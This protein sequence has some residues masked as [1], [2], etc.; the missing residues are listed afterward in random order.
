ML[1]ATR[2]VRLTNWSSNF[3]YLFIILIYIISIFN[4]YFI[5]YILISKWIKIRKS[6]YW[7]ILLWVP[8]FII[9]ISFFAEYFPITNR[10]EIPPPIVGLIVIGLI[11]LYPV[12]LILIITSSHSFISN[13]I[14]KNNQ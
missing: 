12:F 4:I 5:A 2:M 6:N 13:N 14:E 10:G 11:I 9:L 1:N 3:V 7:S 8:Y